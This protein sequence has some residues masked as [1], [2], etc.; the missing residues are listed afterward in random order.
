LV[1]LVQHHNECEVSSD[2]LKVSGGK[3]TYVTVLGTLEEK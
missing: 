3:F 1:E 2:R